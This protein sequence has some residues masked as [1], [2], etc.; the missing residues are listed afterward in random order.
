MW[1]GVDRRQKQDKIGT[2]VNVLNG[3]AWLVFLIALIIF[4]YAR[5]EAEYFVYMLI[6]EPVEVRDFWVKELKAWLYIA[7]YSCVGITATTLVVNRTRL[8]R[9]N[10][11][12]RYGLYLLLVVCV[13]FIGVLLIGKG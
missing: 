3:V 4:H 10:D 2:V 9:R 6:D 5:P 12:E 1:D 8:K 7:L 11:R 13:V